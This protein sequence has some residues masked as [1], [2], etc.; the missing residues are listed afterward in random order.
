MKKDNDFTLNPIGIIHSSF[1]RKG[2]APRQ[3]YLT[4]KKSVLMIFDEY[5][6]GLKDID[7]TDYLIVLYWLDRAERT[8]L[9]TQTPLGPDIKGVF[10]CRSPGRPNPIAFCVVKLLKRKGNSLIV[11]GLDALDKTPLLDIKPYFKSIDSFPE[12]EQ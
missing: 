12:I 2:Q 9:Q 3:G 11:Q 8:T 7:K 5:I 6:E 10:A 1:K 4:K